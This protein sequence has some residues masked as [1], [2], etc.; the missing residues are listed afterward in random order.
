MIAPS[1]SVSTGRQPPHRLRVVAVVVAVAMTGGG[2][3][4]FTVSGLEFW[5]LVRG[6]LTGFLAA[7]MISLFEI[8]YV[9]GDAGER[10]RRTPFPVY[11]GIR[12]LFYLAVILFSLWFAAEVTD[13]RR[14]RIGLFGDVTW[15]DI[16]ISMT[17][18]FVINLGLGLYRL[19]GGRVLG[20]FVTGRYH[21]PRLERRLFLLMD[22]VGS[23]GAADRLGAVAFHPLLNRFHSDIGR[24]V[25]LAGGEIHKYVGDQLIATWPGDADAGPAMAATIDARQRL[26]RAADDYRVTFGLA[27]SFRAVIHAGEVAAGEMGEMRKEIV[28]LGDALNIAARLE[29]VCRERDETLLVTQEALRGCAPPGNLQAVDLG[30]IEIRGT[31]H[32][33][34]V[35]ALRGV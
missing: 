26:Q 11:L 9:R 33:P 13:S 24:A 27:P 18:S 35:F 19:L 5:G 3:Y 30:P 10:F 16:A 14:D 7:G 29:Q 23:S 17:A 8:G 20:S 15:G 21:Q 1:P 34:V 22:M 25:A 32:R 2:V 12:T 31:H 28:Y 4:G 6:L